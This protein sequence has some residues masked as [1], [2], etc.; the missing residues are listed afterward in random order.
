[1]LD[2][3]FTEC[4]EQFVKYY[5]SPTIQIYSLK[6]ASVVEWQTQEPDQMTPMFPCKRKY[7]YLSNAQKLR[8]S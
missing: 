6:Q 4:K 7:G 3:P 1:M 8:E 2:W 5:F